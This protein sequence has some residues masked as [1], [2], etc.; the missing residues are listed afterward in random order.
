M[1]DEA[2]RE[3]DAM[4]KITEALASLTPAARARVLRWVRDVQLAEAER[5]A[6]GG[7]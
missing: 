1:S 6:K 7:G 2:M 4:Q 5:A 3:I